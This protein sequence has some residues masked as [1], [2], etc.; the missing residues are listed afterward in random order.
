[1][2]TDGWS[3]DFTLFNRRKTQEDHLGEDAN[4]LG[5]IPIARRD[6]RVCMLSIRSWEQGNW[7]AL[8]YVPDNLFVECRAELEN[9]LAMH[10]RTHPNHRSSYVPGVTGYE[11]RDAHGH[12]DPDNEPR[13]T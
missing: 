3:G 1:M 7:R 2:Y 11:F 13:Y 5:V 4:Y 8:K 12:T 6:L 10:M 9:I